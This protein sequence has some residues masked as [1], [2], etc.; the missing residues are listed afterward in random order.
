MIVCP[1]CQAP[2]GAPA[3]RVA[4]DGRGRDH[5]YLVCE[6]CGL[7]WVHPPPDPDTLASYY[8]AD[9][10][11]EDEN[12]F[13]P[14]IERWIDRHRRRRARWLAGLTGGRNGR[15]LDIGCGSGR[16]LGM[17]AEMGFE[18]YGMELPGPAAERASRVAGLHLHRG[19]LEDW[20]GPEAS[21]DAV[22]LWH[23]LEHMTDPESVLTRCRRLLKDGG[24]LALEVPNGSSWQARWF[25]TRWFHLDPPRHLFQFTPEALTR[26]L[27]RAGFAEVRWRALQGE[28]GLFGF[29]QSLLNCFVQPRDAFYQ[30][31]RVRHRER[32]ARRFIAFALAA[33]Y[34][35]PAAALTLAESLAGRGAGLRAWARKK[36]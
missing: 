27:D 23:V 22:T 33:A 11:G 17:M 25:Q 8:D 36:D 34:G 26:L 10:Y 21:L 35:V 18:I 19:R 20:P 2:V 4:R 5:S 32:L 7:W 14:R 28:M 3:P 29:L 16:F 15:I 12:K 13:S 24:V 30:G 9:Y 6:S 31:L 1:A